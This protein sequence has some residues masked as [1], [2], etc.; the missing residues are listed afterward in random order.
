MRGREVMNTIQNR[1]ALEVTDVT[2]SNV[3]T[4]FRAARRGGDESRHG[5]TRTCPTW[6]GVPRTRCGAERGETTRRYDACSAD[7][8]ATDTR[9]YE[10]TLS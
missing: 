4:R 9:S 8:R 2:R 7:E 5:C 6:R 10:L 1:D 3:H